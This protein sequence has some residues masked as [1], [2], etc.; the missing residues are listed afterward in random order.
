MLRTLL[1]SLGLIGAAGVAASLLT[2]G[3][4]VWTAEGARRLAVIE[5][6][7]PAP[8]AVLAGPGLSGRSLPKVLSGD[9]HVTLVDFVYTGCPSVC[10]TLGSSFQ[11]LQRALTATAAEDVR[12]LSISFDPAHDGAA[13]LA[14]YAAQWRADSRLWRVATVPDAL[15]LQGLLGAFQVT[16]IAD[17]QGGYAHNAGLL[18]IDQQGRLVR[19]FDADAPEAA[20][21]YARSLLWRGP[22]T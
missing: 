22:A 19:I 9:G 2:E 16:V 15:Q 14:T 8:F 20:L 17:G 18:V 4:E 12:L 13:Q 10:L 1:V 11:Q 21:T 3:F 7:V 6:P 5:R